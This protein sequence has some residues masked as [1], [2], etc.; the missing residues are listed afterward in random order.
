M[1][2]PI[3]LVDCLIDSSAKI[4]WRMQE[5]SKTPIMVEP[6]ILNDISNH[7]KMLCFIYMLNVPLQSWLILTDVHSVGSFFGFN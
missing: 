5:M 1:L 2:L 7:Y 6:F 4:Q 3:C